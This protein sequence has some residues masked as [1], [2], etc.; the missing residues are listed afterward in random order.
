LKTLTTLSVMILL[1][2]CTKQMETYAPKKELNSAPKKQ[3]N[4]AE[5]ASMLSREKT[6]VISAYYKNDMQLA[7]PEVNSED[8]Y[9][10]DGMLNDGWISSLEP[11]IEYH[12][13]FKTLTSDDKILLEWVNFS[14]SPQTYIVDDYKI[15]EWFLL[16]HDDTYT[17]YEVEK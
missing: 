3:L 13:N 14:I 9:T 10:F 17:K 7:I 11:C 8:T 15:D 4:I 12:Y 1:C 2:A 6:Y 5:F 16:K